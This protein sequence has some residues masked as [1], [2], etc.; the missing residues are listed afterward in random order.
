MASAMNNPTPG[1]FSIPDGQESNPRSGRTREMIT[2]DAGHGRY[3]EQTRSG[4]MWTISTP[5]GGIIMTANMVVSV[6][7]HNGIGLYNPIGS[8]VN[9]A[10]QRAIIVV[11]TGIMTTAGGF[12]WGVVPTVSGIT[13]GGV[14]TMKNHYTGTANGGPP[15]A[16][17]Y[18]GSVAVTGSAVS[19]IFRVFGGGPSGTAVIG[20]NLTFEEIVDGDITFGPDTFYGLFQLVAG[21][22]LTIHASITWAEIPI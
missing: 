21:T 14:L 2:G 17:A 19:N 9:I 15:R 13:G 11:V 3:Y 1:I 22:T 4:S 16:K 6:A 18:D 7:S 10:I 20:T 12:T 5:Q 8:G